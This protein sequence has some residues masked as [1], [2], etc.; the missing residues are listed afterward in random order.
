M[1]TNLDCQGFG[2]GF[3]NIF[4][5]K[6]AM[7]YIKARYLHPVGS[8]DRSFRDILLEIRQTCINSR[9]VLSRAPRHIIAEPIATENI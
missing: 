7:F 5:Y 1:I 4:L 8:A 2:K 9:H 6:D 3:P